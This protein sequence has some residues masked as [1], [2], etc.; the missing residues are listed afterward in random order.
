M[1]DVLTEATENQLVDQLELVDVAADLIEHGRPHNAISTKLPELDDILHGGFLPKNLVVLAARPGVGKSAVALSIAIGA[2]EQDHKVLFVSAEM[3]RLEIAM[4]MIAYYSGIPASTTMNAEGQESYSRTEMD[5]LIGAM[6]K[7]G[8][9]PIK[10]IDASVPIAAIRARAQAE[11]M[12]SAPFELIVIDY[13]QIMQPGT[14]RSSDRTRQNEVSDIAR[15]AKD[16]A[17]DLDTVVVA[18]S[19]LNRKTEDRSDK[20]PMLGDLRE[21]GELEQAADTVI[22]LYRDEIYQEASQDAGIIE[23]IVLKQR[24]GRS[25]VTARA[26]W[27]GDRTAVFPLARGYGRATVAHNGQQPLA[28]EPPPGDEEGDA[29]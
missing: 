5:E 21:S 4:R 8:R 27:H 28:E 19:Q 13:L 2:A 7:I 10:V 22:G 25:G 18:L 3:S 14:Q 26:A 23:L 9:L 12:T 29:F 17:M 24:N 11:A 20:R 16:L 15:G 1:V 6:G